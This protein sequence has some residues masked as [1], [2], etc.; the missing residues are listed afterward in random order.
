MSRSHARSGFTL[1]EI[2]VVIGIIAVLAAIIVPNLLTARRAANEK[3]VISTL[4]SIA[5][6]QAVY[7]MDEGN[8]F[9]RLEVL[10]SA[11]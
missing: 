7:Y 1:I 2:L 6:A 3:A 5:S 9:A 11:G 8:R 4:Q 10:E